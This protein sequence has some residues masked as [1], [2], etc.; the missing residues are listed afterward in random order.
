MYS[1]VSTPDFGLT[2]VENDGRSAVRVGMSYR[3]RPYGR[4]QLLDSLSVI[5]LGSFMATG[6]SSSLLQVTI[7]P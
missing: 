5:V 3:S 6:Y 2:C 7:Y 1:P 4:H